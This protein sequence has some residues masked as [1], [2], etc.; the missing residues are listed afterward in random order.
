MKVLLLTPPART[1]VREPIVVP[2][3]GLAYL[4][5]V[6]RDA[7]HEVTILDAL[8]EGLDWRDF[9][10]RISEERHDVVG[11]TAAT[12]TIDTAKRAIALCR[13]HADVLVM[14]G[15]HATAFRH[16]LMKDIP[17]LDYAVYGEGEQ[18]FVSLLRALER[19]DSPDNMAGVITRNGVGPK[20]ECCRDLDELPFP[21]R[22]LLPMGR[23]RYPGF[24]RGPMATLITSRG[25]PYNCIFCDKSV[26][27]SQWRARSAENVLAEIDEVVDRFGVKSI[28]FYDDLFTIDKERVRM[29]C[30]G[31]IARPYTVSW[32]AE[33]RVN[34]VNDEMLSLMKR[35]G[36]DTIAY[37]VES[38]HQKGLDFLGKNTSPDM[39][40][41][42]FEATRKAGIKTLG[43]FILG[44]PI[45]TY[46]EALATIDFAVALKCD[47][48]QFSILCPLP[49]TRL[50]E[51]ADANGWHGEFISDSVD[52]NHPRRPAVVT[53][54]WSPDRL[55]ELLR[56]AHRRFYLRPAYI[57]QS[58]S[59]A[60]SVHELGEMGALGFQVL[61][62]A[63]RRVAG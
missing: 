56:L 57:V 13:P 22:D 41:H 58:L 28:V 62:Y 16:D 31:L 43:Y 42:A 15:P 21:A 29:I 51:L 44:L 32:K 1:K 37:G 39:I 18:T 33:S 59:R 35:A 25:C 50:N 10:E 26:F 48:A 45:E 12:M 52:A 40:R 11:V 23:Y 47:F 30:E 14:G 36:C 8:A 49:G 19:G 9:Q 27:G 17:E 2:P 53:A 6:A 24:R 34:I 55:A 46:E 20:R 5:A 61:K 38:S 54:T 63:L 60:R 3:L 7:G 4:A